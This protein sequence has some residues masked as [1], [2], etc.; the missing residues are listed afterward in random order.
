MATRLY[1]PNSAQSTPITPA[2]DADWEDS[3]GLVRSL[4]STTPGGDAMATQSFVD[5]NQAN[6]DICFHQFVS[7]ELVAGQ[8]V[9]GAQALKLQALCTERATTNNMFLTMGIRII[10]A[11]GST[12]QK[13]VLPV[14]RDDQGIDATALT[15]RQYT[16]TSAVTNYTTVAGDRIVIEIGT[17]GDPNPGS[18]HDSDIR[19]GDAAASDLPEDNSTTTD[20]RPWVEF[21]DT[22]QFVSAG[23]A[24]GIFAMPEP[25]QFVSAMIRNSW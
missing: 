11:D 14:S 9:T 15:N 12:V 22:L 16:A 13:T 20:L 25:D 10:A 18:D 21:T 6:R 5:N 23:N 17:G 2:V 19:F 8:T 4:T 7:G 3:S 24:L 1:L